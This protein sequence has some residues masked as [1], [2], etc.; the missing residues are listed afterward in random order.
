[1]APTHHRD[2]SVANAKA[3]PITPCARLTPRLTVPNL[4][5][6]NMQ[7]IDIFTCRSKGRED[8]VFDPRCVCNPS[9]TPDLI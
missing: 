6:H 2:T 9:T 1:V 8:H 7:S 5:I 3:S 4:S